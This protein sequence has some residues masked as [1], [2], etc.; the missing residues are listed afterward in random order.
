MRFHSPPPTAAASTDSSIP[1][2]TDSASRAGSPRGTTIHT[3]SAGKT[4]TK[5]VATTACGSQ[6]TVRG[7]ICVG[8]TRTEGIAVDVGIR[9]PGLEQANG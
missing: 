8:A 5:A 9:P 4:T 6:R 1:S 3:T 2:R 7:A